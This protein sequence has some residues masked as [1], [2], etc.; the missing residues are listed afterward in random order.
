MSDPS[1]STIFQLGN[2][3]GG[4]RGSQEV[5]N[6]YIAIW[7]NTNREMGLLITGLVGH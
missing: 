2:Q 3:T 4:T 5:Y 7:Q 1:M 6:Q